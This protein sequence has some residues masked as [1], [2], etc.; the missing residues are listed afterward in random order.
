[1]KERPII[2][3]GESVRT[4]LDG[5]KTQTRRVIT[6][7]GGND[8]HIDRLLGEW[9]LS[10]HPVSYEEAK[11][12]FDDY[13]PWRPTRGPKPGDW[14]WT[15]QTDVDDTACHVFRCPHGVPGDVLWVRE[16][17]QHL[18]YGGDD[19]VVYRATCI[20]DCFGW[21]PGEGVIEQIKIKSWRPSI[22]MPKWA[23]R[24][25]L[26]VTDVRVERVQEISEE[27][28]RAEGCVCDVEIERQLPGGEPA[29]YTG[30][31]ATERFEEGWD[32]L[33]A[34]RGFGWAKN[35]WVWA[36]TFERIED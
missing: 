34:K 10:E 24:L 21:S 9:S 13:Y 18:E 11:A 27:D 14:L 28:A 4:I 7:S 23:C 20:N 8:V 26:R 35:P 6:N 1:M 17:W 22:H 25:R 36:L 33:N 29:D 3:S 32:A 15:L 19:I 31:Y 30:L 5:R 2:F 12:S 16:T